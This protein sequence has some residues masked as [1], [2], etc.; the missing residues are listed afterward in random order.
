M[1]EN[2]DKYQV[3]PTQRT[4]TVLTVNPELS[5]FVRRRPVE[6]VRAIDTGGDWLFGLELRQINTLTLAKLRALGPDG[7]T[8]SVTSLSLMNWPN[9]IEIRHSAI[10]VNASGAGFV[11][12]SFDDRHELEL[13]TRAVKLA[14]LRTFYPD[15]VEMLAPWVTFALTA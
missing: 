14:E 2:F 3:H 10:E 11:T 12:I 9:T 1:L 5:V 13:E 4:K 15:G 8:V 6:A 7:T